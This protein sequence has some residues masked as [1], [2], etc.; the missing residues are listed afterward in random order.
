MDLHSLT[1][2]C[3]LAIIAGLIESRDQQYLE[4]EGVEVVPEMLDTMR[5]QSCVCCRRVGRD[6]E[7]SFGF[8][9]MSDVDGDDSVGLIGFCAPHL[10]AF[11]RGLES[12]DAED[13]VTGEQRVNLGRWRCRQIHRIILTGWLAWRGSSVL[14][15]GQGRI[16]KERPTC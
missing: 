6:D 2:L 10:L 5:A 14:A 16:P 3:L 13:E 4:L 8:I 9:P 12:D 15:A 1:E 11:V 7:E